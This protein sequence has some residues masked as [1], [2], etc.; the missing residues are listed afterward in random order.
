MRIFLITMILVFMSALTTRYRDGWPS[1]LRV[2]AKLGLDALA[3]TGRFAHHL[4][5]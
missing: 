5:S 3:V 4:A 1:R 2:G